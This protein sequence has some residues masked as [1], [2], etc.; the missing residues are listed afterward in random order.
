MKN[1]VSIVTIVAL[2]N[3]PSIINKRL[4][5]RFIFK[6]ELIRHPVHAPVT[7]KG[8]AQKALG[9]NTCKIQ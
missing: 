8:I 5:F 1:S 2:I 3:I 9:R 7:G 4:F 6:M